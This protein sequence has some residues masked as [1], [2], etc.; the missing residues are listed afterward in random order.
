MKAPWQASGLVDALARALTT[1]RNSVRSDARSAERYLLHSLQTASSYCCVG[2]ASHHRRRHP[3]E[4]TKLSGV[5]VP[6]G[7][8][9]MTEPAPAHQPKVLCTTLGVGWWEA[10]EHRLHAQIQATA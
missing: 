9:G 2:G 6:P 10:T 5:R 8:T 4:H 3:D 1:L 7:E